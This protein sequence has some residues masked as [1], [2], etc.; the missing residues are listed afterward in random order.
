M[1]TPALLA[2]RLGIA[3]AFAF[4]GAAFAATATAGGFTYRQHN[5]VSDG[6]I[7][8]DHLD[9]NLVNAWGVTF[10]P[11]GAVWVANNGTGTS[12]LYDGSGNAIPLV[13]QIPSPGTD[14]GGTPTGIAYNGS[15]SFVVSQAG[16]SGPARFLFATEDGVIAGWAPTVDSTHAIRAIDNSASG[17]VYKGIALSA[18]GNGALLYASDFHNAKVDV[19]DANLHPV[20][21]GAGAF[22]DPGIPLG[23]AP[24][25][26]QAIGG[27]IYVTFAKQDADRHDEIDGPGLGYVDAF[28]P[29]GH[30]LRRIATRGAL[31]APW[32]LAL[33]PAGFGAFGNLLLIGNFGDGHINAYE[34]AL[35]FF[36]GSLRGQDFRPLKIDGLWGLGFGNGYANQPVDTL[37]FAAGPDGEAHGLYG[38]IE[39]TQ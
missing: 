34:P 13:V 30:L 32:G 24:F 18:G 38:R 36:V 33:A 39:P 17:T 15:S 29:N 4:A 12:T 8:A 26:I 16:L 22:R 31:N 1:R 23:Y 21:L 27:D 7:A 6:F 28:D 5:L 35:G 11:T 37:F 25:G 20:M 10:N 2:Q 9:P 19:F 14:N 3:A